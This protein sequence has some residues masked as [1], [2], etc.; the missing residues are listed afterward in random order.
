[1]QNTTITG[2]LYL[3]EGIGA[4]DV[5]LDNVTVQGTTKISG[6]GSN[7]IHLLNTSVSSVLVNVPSRN[8]VRVLAQ[9]STDVG[10][11]EARTPAKLEEEG[12]PA[13]VLPRWL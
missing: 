4:G 8:L 5:T 7:S 9:G 3:T 11:L 12:L 1:M 10:T 13:L 2:N 6:G